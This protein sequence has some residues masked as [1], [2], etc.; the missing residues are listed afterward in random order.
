MAN[1]IDEAPLLGI[2]GDQVSKILPFKTPDKGIFTFRAK[3]D[4]YGCINICPSSMRNAIYGR[5]GDDVS[6]KNSG[7]NDLFQDI[8]NNIPAVQLREYA[9]DSRIVQIYN[10]FSAFKDGY[11]KYRDIAQDKGKWAALWQSLKGISS[12]LVDQIGK[13][14][15]RAF[16]KGVDTSIAKF[17]NENLRKSIL[18]IPFML[19]YQIMTTKT[20]GYYVLPYSGK[21]VDK[22]DGSKGWNTKHGW[23]GLDTSEN[24]LLGTMLNFFGRNIKLNTTP[25]WDGNTENNYPQMT[26]QFDLFNDSEKSALNNFIFLH[27]IFPKNKFLQ[28]NIFQHNPCVYDVKI[29]GYGRFYMCSGD[30][31]CDYKGVSRRP[32]NKFFSELAA[33]TEKNYE[34]LTKDVLEKQKLIRIPDIYSVKIDLTSLLPNSINNY[35]FSFSGNHNMEGGD[36]GNIEGVGQKLGSAIENAIDAAYNGAK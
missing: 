24:S 29:E 25:L 20:N 36:F 17:S 15:V 16:E 11:E 26:V 14:P 12:T 10:L 33:K 9:Q 19:Y 3:P 27:H 23:D 6:F 1:G 5:I 2:E 35:L 8:L 28:Y 30:M 18:D 21:L 4:S 32:S 13:I 31:Q 34:G 7:S 22:S